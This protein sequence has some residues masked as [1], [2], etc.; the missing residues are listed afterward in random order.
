MKLI[1]IE[2]QLMGLKQ[3]IA[4]YDHVN[5]KLEQ[6]EIEFNK[7][8]RVVEL[9][10]SK[11]VEEENDVKKLESFSL[12]S[13]WFS[14]I[15]SKTERLMKERDE[16]S[17][18][19][20]AYNRAVATLT[21]L[22]AEID[23]YRGKLRVMNEHKRELERLL[24]EK[25]VQLVTENYP[26]KAL[27]IDYNQKLLQFEAQKKEIVEAISAGRPLLKAFNQVSQSL[28]KAKNWGTYEELGGGFL[29]NMSKNSHIDNAKK[30]IQSLEYL[31]KKFAR[32][33][34]DVNESVHVSIEI[35]GT[36]S[37]MDFFFDGL[38]VDL[39]V[40]Q[41]I[42]HAMTQVKQQE[43]LVK[44]ALERL[45]RALQT[46]EQEMSQVR[47]SKREFLEKPFN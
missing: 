19:L 45:N 7:Q 8:H 26:E 25:E 5:H 10:K 20:Y 31:A 33:L 37:F 12:G 35:G 11:L 18:A 15:G 23:S 28:T 38:F 21:P 13:L 47:K 30:A 46:N 29:S 16:A 40:Q 44:S 34:K 32:E 42:K 3:K 14:M 36:L 41:K 6:A 17:N 27:L 4:D 43:S 1:E 9:L 22:E 2:E 24:K 39:A